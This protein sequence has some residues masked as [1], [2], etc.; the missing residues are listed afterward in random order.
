MSK[1]IL[2]GSEIEFSK[3]EDNFYNLQSFL[4][5]AKNEIE[6]IYKSWYQNQES[7]ANVINNCESFTK[8]TIES[9]VIYPLYSTLAEDF[10]LFGIG[11]EDYVETCFDIS[12]IYSVRSDAI[13]VYN[14]I[15]EQLEAEIEEREFNNEVRKAGQISFGVGDS[16]K[17]AASNA[18]HGIA[19]SSGNASSREAA[20][21]KRG[22]LYNEFREALW[23]AIKE[24]IVTCIENHRD[25]VNDAVP[26]SILSG[27][28]RDS[29]EAYLEN[30]KKF[31][32]NRKE[33]LVKSF[34][35][36]PWNEE[37][38]KY[39]FSVYPEERKNIIAIASNYEVSLMSEVN[40]IL[41]SHYSQ[42]AKNDENLAL[43][44]KAKIKQIMFDLGVEESSVI[45]E[46]ENDC[47]ERLVVGLVTADEKQCNEMKEK[48]DKYDA[49]T[50][51]KK[52]FF[53]R[54][55]HRLETI[56]AKEDGEIFDNY[57]LQANILSEKAVEDGKA[58]I[59]EK[60]RTKSADIYMTAFEH[61][62]KKI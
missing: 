37:I 2:L 40:N 38:Y 51:N 14:D 9:K 18:A 47:L 48:I 22:A 50:R 6:V 45:D 1:Y 58:Y 59:K 3:A 21:K 5:K 23:E 39:I 53:D 7:I 56:W 25:F 34:M 60:K 30:A 42:A 41:K 49:L 8:K 35:K 54:I 4:W 19:N 62:T 36:C 44:A 13:D 46:I 15:Q 20:N 31:P 43:E 26:N 17:N 61:C 32:E 12:A 57:L 28:D 16:I 52:S 11:K 29:A 24:S 33:L 55:T 27:F 10:Q